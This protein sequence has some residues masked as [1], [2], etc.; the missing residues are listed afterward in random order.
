LVPKV[1]V[2]IPTYNRARLVGNAIQSILD[3]TFQDF[4]VIV[5]DDGSDDNT[6]DVISNFGEK[7]IYIYQENK[8]R[9]VARNNGMRHAKGHYITFLDSDDIYLPDKLQVQVESMEKN[10]DF[11]MSYSYSI[12]LNEVGEYLHTWRDDLNGRIF[13]ELM[14][15]RHNKITV[16]SVMIRRAVL[17]DVGYFNESIN[18]CEDY[19]YWCRI[20]M[21]HSVLLIRKAL[22]I[23]NTNTKPTREIFYSYFTSTLFYYQSIFNLD[24]SVKKSMKRTIFLNLSVKYYLNS[25]SEEQKKF[26][27]SGIKKINSSYVYLTLLITYLLRFS[28]S[29]KKYNGVRTLLAF[30]N[31]YLLIR[32]PQFIMAEDLEYAVLKELKNEKQG[33]LISHFYIKRESENVYILTR[34][35]NRNNRKAIRELLINSNYWHKNRIALML[36]L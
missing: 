29:F 8:E 11:G 21:K 30:Y 7:V 33:E 2:I 10:S 23:I 26:V 24:H 17:E 6:R 3:Q 4:E 5:V 16:P 32:L 1:S 35:I 18:T 20:A 12:W 14:Q 27:L 15:A 36:N 34:G 25:T 28:R 9:S 31:N 13:P 19:E 22:V